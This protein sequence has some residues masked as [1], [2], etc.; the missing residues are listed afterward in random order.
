MLLAYAKSI[1]A[2]MAGLTEHCCSPTMAGL[3]AILAIAA[4]AVLLIL[5]FGLTT[6]PERA[7]PTLITLLPQMP[8]MALAVAAALS[9][10]FHR[11]RVVYTTIALG[12]AYTAFGI[13]PAGGTTDL[14]AVFAALC[15][16]VPGVVALL[17]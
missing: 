10:I 2:R 16:L 1:F 4:P 11:G 7:P 17:A 3:R 14:S 12:V 15:V 9:L 13:F 8:Y 5:A 6:R